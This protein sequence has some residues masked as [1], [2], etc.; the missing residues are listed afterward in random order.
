[1]D[2]TLAEILLHRKLPAAKL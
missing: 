2:D 1:M